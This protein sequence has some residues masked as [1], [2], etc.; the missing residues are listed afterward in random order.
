MTP[1]SATTG[2]RRGHLGPW[3]AGQIARWIVEAKLAADDPLPSESELA[4]RYD[5]SVRVIRDA[6]RILTSQGVLT[7]SQGRRAV[8]ANRPSEAI[9]GYFE[10]ATASDSSAIAELF[11]VRIALESRSARL[12][13]D[14]ATAD[15]IDAIRAALNAMRASSGQIESYADADLAWHAG[16]V[17][18][19]HN[20]FLVGIH[21]ALAHI[22]RTERI[23][24]VT[25]RLRAGNSASTTLDEHAA[26]TDAIE[27][28]DPDRA[29]RAMTAHLDRAR[30]LYVDYLESKGSDKG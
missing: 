2:A 14:H 4:A 7:T 1:D 25:M 28:H 10:F 5:V 20:R 17:R 9:Q 21:T 11:E 24:G 13:A 23:S 19:S 30:L 6:L 27:A 3:V 29:E 15:E 26:V 22:L 8:V 12:A 18:G 16:V